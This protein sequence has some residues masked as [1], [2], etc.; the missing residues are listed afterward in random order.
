MHGQ[1]HNRSTWYVYPQVLVVV[2]RQMATWSEHTLTVGR[3][4]LAC[5]VLTADAAQV[6]CHAI[7]C[8]TV[9]GWSSARRDHVSTLV[10]RSCLWQRV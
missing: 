4:R 8:S 6:G 2:E 7:E 9:D 3:S 10:S 1:E 5:G